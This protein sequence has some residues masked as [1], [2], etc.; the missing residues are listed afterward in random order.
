MAPSSSPLSQMLRSVSSAK[1]D[2]LSKRRAL[3]ERQKATVFKEVGASPL[4]RDRVRILL[5][6]LNSLP[7]SPPGSLGVAVSNRHT[8]IGVDSDD[9]GSDSEWSNM[10]QFLGQSQHDSP[11]SSVMLADWERKLRQDIEREGL[12]YE[13]ATLFGEILT[14]WSSEQNSQTAAAAGTDTLDA[15]EEIGEKDS[16]EYREVFESYVFTAH[17]TDTV[18]IES[19]LETLFSS[20]PE[21]KK[22]LEDLRDEIKEFGEDEL[23]SVPAISETDLEQ[24]IDSLL[25]TDM[26][27]NEKKAMLAD[28]W[29]NDVLTAELGDVLRLR[30]AS[31]DTWSWGKKAVPVEARQGLDGKYE[32]YE[33]EDILQAIF[34]H[35]LGVRWGSTFK[36][37]LVEFSRTPAWK[38]LSKPVPNEYLRRRMHFLNDFMPPPLPP[39]PPPPSQYMPPPPPPPPPPAWSSPPM[40]PLPPPPPPPSMWMH[41]TI[42]TQRRA[43]FSRHFMT[44]LPSYSTGPRRCIDLSI[45]YVTAKSETLHQALPH[46]VATES[47]IHTSIHGHFTVLRSGLKWFGLSLPHSTILTVLEFFGVPSKWLSFFKK[48]LECPVKFTEDGP[49]GQTQTRVRGVPASHA[50]SVLFGEIL[51]FCMDYAVN[52]GADGALLYRLHDDFWVWGQENTCVEAWDAV[53]QFTKVMGVSFDKEKTGTAQISQNKAKPK[54]LTDRLPKGEV[55]WGMLQLDSTTGQFVVNQKEVNTHTKEL[56]LKLSAC[57]SILAWV[58]TWNTYMEKLFADNFAEPAHC[59]GRGYVDTIIKTFER[60]QRELFT[61]NEGATEHLR[62]EIAKRFG[63][64][65]IPDGF[66]YFPAQLGGLELHNPLINLYAVRNSVSENPARAIER[67]LAD[68]EALHR[69]KRRQPRKSLSPLPGGGI[70]T[71]EEL[72][73]HRE[74]TS[75]QFGDAY[76]YLL[77]IPAAKVG[78]PTPELTAALDRVPYYGDCGVDSDWRDMG[79]YYQSVVRL[80][81]ADL[82]ER[83]GSLTIVEER[84]LPASLVDLFREKRQKREIIPDD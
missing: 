2:E 65:N 9:E 37:H 8:L 40:P 47:L 21:S 51:L 58:R 28:L 60:F 32:I 22:A 69:R 62:A 64:A 10:K 29:E 77:T 20:N 38:P 55:R 57:K 27:T 49:D 53:K 84:F 76:K 6:A 56:K 42:Q 81:G 17:E 80:Y 46:L 30:L 67:A 74:D 16:H 25:A 54:T 31:L 4:P 11:V 13:Y 79:T 61:A 68:E 59:L 75:S 1:L 43:D 23:P 33:D 78:S 73:S 35:Y 44:Q 39:P 72:R 18:A 3:F 50:L 12:K 36:K 14:E 7:G 5:D 71:L 83:V 26:L 70:F 19:Y 41:S 48:F 52:Q 34:L 66:I 24:C 82:L 15:F 63:V 45:D